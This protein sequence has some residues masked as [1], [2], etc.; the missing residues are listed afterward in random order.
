MVVV[1]VVRHRPP[2]LLLTLLARLG[3][4]FGRPKRPESPDPV[5]TTP[6]KRARLRVGTR[7]AA[8]TEARRFRRSTAAL[9]TSPRLQ[10]KKGRP[11][12][13]D[14]PPRQQ[15]LKEGDRWRRVE[16]A[17]CGRVGRVSSLQVFRRRRTETTPRFPPQRKETAT[18]R[19]SVFRSAVAGREGEPSAPDTGAPVGAGRGP[20]FLRNRSRP[21]RVSSPLGP[22]LRST[23]TLSQLPRSRAGPSSGTSLNPI[24]AD[25][26]VGN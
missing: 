7:S 11:E 23:P 17:V 21:C 25:E 10:R 14:L 16:A 24:V 6:R 13:G 20:P 9:P 22:R 18:D 8:A 15:H 12:D 26:T 5:V 3:S 4:R 1:V 19:G 2:F